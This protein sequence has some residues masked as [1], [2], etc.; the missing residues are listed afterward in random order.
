MVVRLPA[1][2]MCRPREAP[3]LGSPPWLGHHILAGLKHQ[4]AL[5]VHTTSVRRS[6]L[7]EGGRVA[8]ALGSSHLVAP[9]RT[10]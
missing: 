2:A 6:T 7:D 10:L 5:T 3:S 8:M 4:P 1:E 9:S